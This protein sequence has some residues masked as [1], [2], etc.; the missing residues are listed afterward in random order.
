MDT[1]G[2]GMH[3]AVAATLLLFTAS[4]CHPSTP[5]TFFDW[6][7]PEKASPIAETWIERRSLPITDRNSGEKFLWPVE[8]E[9][10]ARFDLKSRPQNAGIDIA[11]APG[12]PIRASAAGVVIYVGNEL[13]S[14]GNLLLI[15]HH[16]AY[17]TAY[18]HA[19]RYTIKK[20]DLVERGQ[21]IGFSGGTNGRQTA[22]HF[23]I[24][25]AAK[26][27]DPLTF[28]QPK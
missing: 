15:E 28:L 17:V 14:Y 10:I 23:E 20:G 26:P 12:T 6:G 1:M 11:A 16:S 5:Q 4:G 22:M 25:R 21:V 13:A 19:Q 24:R 27:V 3:R 18:A 7:I 9:L 2:L 8:G